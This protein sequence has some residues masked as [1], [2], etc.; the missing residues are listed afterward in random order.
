MELF[1]L[2]FFAGYDFGKIVKFEPGTLCSERVK[3]DYFVTWII[4]IFN[5]SI[6]FVKFNNKLVSR[7][8]ESSHY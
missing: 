1:I 5:S 2:Q 4:L 6:M 8:P 7:P 3:V